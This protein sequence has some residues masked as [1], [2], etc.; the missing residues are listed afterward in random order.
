MNPLDKI[1]RAATVVF[2]YS[3]LEKKPIHVCSHMPIGKN[4]R[5]HFWI[6]FNLSP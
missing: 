6:M 1:P 5:D 3:Q 2:I 4:T